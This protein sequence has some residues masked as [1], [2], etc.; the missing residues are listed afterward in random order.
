MTT[1]TVG[2]AK[3]TRVEESYGHFFAAKTFFTD[4]RDDVVAG[5]MGWMV[6]DQNPDRHLRRQSQIA[7][8]SAVLGQ[9]QY[10][11]HRTARSRRREA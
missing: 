1:A 9:S 5:H 7:Q 8:A 6:P 11:L 2:A 4:W 10:A 3:I